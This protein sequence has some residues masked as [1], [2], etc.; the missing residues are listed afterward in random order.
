[1]MMGKDFLEKR[2]KKLISFMKENDID[3]SVVSSPENVF[4]YS[5]FNP[6]IGSHPAFVIIKKTG[7]YILLVHC[8][9]NAHAQEE[10][11][12]NNILLY[13][14]WGKN[15]PIALD[16]MDAIEI[17]LKEKNLKI[18]LEKKFSSIEFC[19][20]LGE[21]NKN[22][23][24]F[25]ISKFISNEKII[26]DEYEISCIKKAAFLTDIGVETAIEYLKKGYSEAEACTEGQYQMRKAWH[27]Y[28]PDCEVSGFWTSEGGQVDSLVV[29][30]MA[31]ERI[32]YGCDCP[33]HYVPKD[34]DIVLPMA[35]ARVN[36]YAAE[37]ERTIIL[38]EEN[39]FV[40]KAY[41]SVLKAREEVFKILKP[42]TSFE[43]LYLAAEKV[44][45]ENGFKE[46][47]PGRIGHGLGL[48]THEFPSLAKGNKLKLSPGMVF[49][50]EPGL[51]SKDWGGVRH[52]DT[53]L[54][55][56]DGFEFLTKLNR[57]KIVIK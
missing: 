23:N 43:E 11:F 36:G 6:I 14:K 54:I 57:D 13:G 35:W 27:K 48:S 56:E 31:N 55:T 44:F 18:G 20:K 39:E 29:W 47:L 24:F 9:R 41:L 17:I 21:K 40:N 42:G 3:V 46:I 32:S 2:I 26:K 53:V 19:E 7:E 30:S 8:I 5:N 50:V 28:F 22:S 16:Y 38:K 52:S 33:I 49:T 45:I 1:M 12:V 34:G 51:M 10:S 25:D 37:N 4:Y 15:T